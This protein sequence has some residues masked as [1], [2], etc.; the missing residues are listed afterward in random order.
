MMS[1]KILIIDGHPVYANKMVEFFQELTF[2][3]IY[4]ATTGKQGMDLVQSRNLDLIVLSAILPDK[5]GLEICKNI[6][7]ITKGSVKIIVQ[8]GLFAEEKDIKQFKD[9]GANDVLVRKEKDLKPLQN[10]I[11]ELLFSRI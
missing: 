3:D 5:D 10:A 11:E 7:E 8:T 9:Y 2:E 6:N 4:L 1:Q